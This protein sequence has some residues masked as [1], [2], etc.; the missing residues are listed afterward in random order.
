MDPTYLGP[1]S[2][3]VF[4]GFILGFGLIKTN[5]NVKAALGVVGSAL[6]GGPIFFIEGLGLARW[7]YPIG[8]LLG[9][10]W[11]R[12]PNAIK[13]LAE[14]RSNPSKARSVHAKWACLEIAGILAVSFGL[15]VCAISTKSALQPSSSVS[16]KLVKPELNTLVQMVLECQSR[17][18]EIEKLPV[19]EDITIS[20]W[21]LADNAIRGYHQ[22]NSDFK[23]DKLQGLLLSLS[24]TFPDKKNV[25]KTLAEKVLQLNDLFKVVQSEHKTDGLQGSY[26]VYKFD[27]RQQEKLRKI[28]EYI[29]TN[30]GIFDEMLSLGQ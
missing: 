30:V 2:L 26:L 11:L 15:V 14:H 23:E 17:L 1:L 25:L 28:I 9:I 24:V 16:S 3:G 20:E 7:W 10:A 6:G 19:R 22:L 5:P 21:G 18:S 8:L 27:R 4:V 12:V 13:V 29:S